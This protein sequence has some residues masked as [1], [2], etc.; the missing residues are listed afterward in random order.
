MSTLL[1]YFCLRIILMLKFI[2]NV[3]LSLVYR[4]LRGDMIE[5][6]KV[7]SGAYDEQAMPAIVTT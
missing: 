1:F 2:P 4:R 6:F 7:V 5:M 3:V